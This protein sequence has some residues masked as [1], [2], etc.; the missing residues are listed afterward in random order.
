ML[1]SNLRHL[2]GDRTLC[3]TKAARVVRQTI[4]SPSV[5]SSVSYKTITLPLELTAAKRI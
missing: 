1:G 5:I 2:S 3:T 4:C